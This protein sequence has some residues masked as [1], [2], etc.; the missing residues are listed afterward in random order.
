MSRRTPS[1]SALVTS[2]PQLL[3][4]GRGPVRSGS[5]DAEQHSSRLVRGNNGIFWPRPRHRRASTGSWNVLRYRCSRRRP[6]GQA[7]D[8]RVILGQLFQQLW[9]TVRRQQ[10]DLVTTQR[11]AKT[12]L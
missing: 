10:I 7:I 11:G 8:V 2:S 1:A 9:R 6:V 12:E 3:A 4:C 5:P